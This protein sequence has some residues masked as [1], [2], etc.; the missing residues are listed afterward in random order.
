MKK[1]CSECGHALTHE[2][3]PNVAKSPRKTRTKEELIEAGIG[4][5]SDVDVAY[6]LGVSRERVRQLRI[7]FCI[8]KPTTK[9]KSLVKLDEV[10]ALAAQDADAYSISAQTGVSVNS[11]NTL[12][13]AYGFTVNTKQNT[14]LVSDQQI[15]EAISKFRTITEAAGFLGMYAPHLSRMINNRPGL[16]EKVYAV[17][18][19]KGCVADK[20]GVPKAAGAGIYVRKPPKPPKTPEER[21]A[22]WRERYH[23]NKRNKQEQEQ[24]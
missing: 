5:I 23:R 22:A 16:Q 11:I 18:L 12:A 6:K 1:F 10:R 3:E 14:Y 20:N 17:R 4:Q 7:E 2:K 9:S 21:R 19:A 15:L 24:K 8:D 13:K